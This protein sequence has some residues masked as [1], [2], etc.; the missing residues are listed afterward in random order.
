MSE[1][2]QVAEKDITMNFVTSYSQAG[3]KYEFLLILYLP[4]LWSKKS[5]NNIQKALL[6]LLID[7]FKITSNEVFIL[8]NTIES[9][10]VIENGKE[11]TW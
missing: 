7:T 9:G 4:T 3:Q 1:K 10:N 2:I 5:I 6:E 8:T 11:V